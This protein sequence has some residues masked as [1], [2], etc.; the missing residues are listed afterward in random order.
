M[1]IMKVVHQYFR[2]VKYTKSN[3]N[4]TIKLDGGFSSLDGDQILMKNLEIF[5]RRLNDPLSQLLFFGDQLNVSSLPK[6]LHRLT[7]HGVIHELKKRFFKFVLC[8]CAHAF[9][10]V[11]VGLEPW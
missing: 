5:K 9:I 2:Q 7:K 8:S 11:N 6:I 10:K 4:W 3:V 1:K